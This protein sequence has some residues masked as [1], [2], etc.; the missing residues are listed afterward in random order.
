MNGLPFSRRP[1]TRLP[2]EVLEKIM[3]S[4]LTKRQLKIILQVCR[5]TYGCQVRVAAFKNSDF[6]WC[7]VSPT[8]IKE[9][10][11]ELQKLNVIT[12]C[13]DGLIGLNPNLG[14]WKCEMNLSE[15]VIIEL[16]SETLS[17]QLTA[18]PIL[19]IFDPEIL[20][21]TKLDTRLKEIIKKVNKGKRLSKKEARD[22]VRAYQPN[23]KEFAKRF[24][25]RHDSDDDYPHV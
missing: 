11:E 4:D 8:A 3:E 6:I 12:L 21:N 25:V 7:G 18:V 16:R 23:L 17:K 15:S 10:L 9:E 2:N 5:L 19:N 13:E 22:I 1:F 14:E 24:T 20:N